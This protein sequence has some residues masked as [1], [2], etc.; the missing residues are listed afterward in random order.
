MQMNTNITLSVFFATLNLWPSVD[1][2]S[3]GRLRSQGTSRQI[4]LFVVGRADVGQLSNDVRPGPGFML[5]SCLR[6]GARSAY[7]PT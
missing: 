1:V 4:C 7:S 5:A 6:A 2:T 3:R